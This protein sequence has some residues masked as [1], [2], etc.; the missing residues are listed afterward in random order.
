MVSVIKALII[1]D[2]EN[3]KF[4]MKDDAESARL[5]K[6][7]MELP[8]MKA[9][10]E[11][12]NKADLTKQAIDLKAEE[13]STKLNVIGRKLKQIFLSYCKEIKMPG[14]DHR[15]INILDLK[16]FLKYFKDF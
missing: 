6:E 7:I 5:I 14:D 10:I 9:A 16:L 2:I 4:I 11:K 3:K 12:G 8:D 1:W 13:F 15:S